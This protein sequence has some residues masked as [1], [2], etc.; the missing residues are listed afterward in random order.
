MNEYYTLSKVKIA[1][2]VCALVVGCI[3]YDQFFVQ[4]VSAQNEDAAA[5]PTTVSAA[6]VSLLNKIEAIKLDDTIF[7]DPVFKS[8][9]DFSV[10]ITLDQKDV[11]RPNPFA[12][13]PKS[14][15]SQTRG[16]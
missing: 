13:I 2:I 9:Q 8:L 12:P 5:A 4:N 16:R 14:P 3:A 10:E 1:F 6:A 11:G 7:T 15:T